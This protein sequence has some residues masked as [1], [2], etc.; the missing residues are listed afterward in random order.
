M[1]R[2]RNIKPSIFKNELLGQADPMLTILFTS[3]WTLADR[4]GRLEDRPLRIK[5]E[6]FPYRDLPLFN[7]YLTELQQ[8][9]FIDRYSVD[10]KAIIQIINFFKHQSPHSTEKVSEL[11]ENHHPE[12]ITVKEP[13]S[14]GEVTKQERPDSLI[15]DSLNL[16]PDSRKPRTSALD[17]FSAFWESYPNKTGKKKAKE[18]WKR[19]KPILVDVLKAIAWQKKTD[20]WK[21]GFIPNPTTWLNEERWEDEPLQT[22]KTDLEKWSKT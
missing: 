18:L 7:G 14:N 16:I 17:S 19:N 11:P 22:N 9:G 15:P 6:T 12:P 5:A 8:L 2:A 13:L 20:K 21:K 10:G 1:A 3:L 4:E